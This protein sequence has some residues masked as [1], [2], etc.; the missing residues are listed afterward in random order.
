MFTSNIRS[1]SLVS[2]LL[3][4]AVVGCVRSSTPTVVPSAVKPPVVAAPPIPPPMP[5][6]ETPEP[7]PPEPVVAAEVP[8]EKPD[9]KP[10]ATERLLLLAPQGPLIV[11]FELWI[12]GQ[13]QAD[14]FDRLL[15]E[16]LKLADTDLDGTATWKEVTTSPKFRYGQFGNLPI[17]R[18]NAP[19]QIIQQYDLDGDGRVDLA[20]LPRFLTR[21][22]GGA[23]AFSVRSIEQF[24]GRNRR[25]SPTWRALDTDN[26]GQLTKAE[27]EA[28]A[29][30]LRLLD[31]D[32]DET[33]VVGELRRTTEVELMPGNR[34]RGIRGDFARVLGEH[35]NWD[36]IRAALEE[37]YALGGTL[38]SDDFGEQRELFIHLDEDKDGKIG[39]KEFP[40]LNTAR[41]N[42][43]LRL[44]FGQPTVS[45]AGSPRTSPMIDVAY[46]NL[47]PSREGSFPTVISWPNRVTFRSP[48]VSLKFVRNDTLAT[49]DF[50]AQAQQGLAM[51]DA[52]ANGY[53][54]SS[55]VSAAVQQQFGRFEALD[56]DADGKVY[57]LEIT[58]FLR[59]RQGA[60]RVQVHARVQDQEDSLF[61]ALD[62]N[63]DDRLDARELER[64]AARLQQL[65]A[66]SDGAITVDELPEEIVI[67]IA[68]GSI[69]N[70]EQLFAVGPVETR[71]PSENL[72]SWF[73]AMDTS[74][75]G[76][77]SAKEFLGSAEKF[78]T[79]DRNQNG[80]FEPDEIPQPTSPTKEVIP[81]PAESTERNEP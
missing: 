45:Q 26:D 17:D 16:V 41:S 32:D 48:G 81:L 66:N 11:E 52:D 58:D 25:G 20:E 14:E 47:L 40:R 10:L 29:A 76:V 31:S 37:Q 71:A 43:F 78:A 64:A 61:L 69:E 2:I 27:I 73:A 74:R 28:A 22:A 8:T 54:E 42:L 63:A 36:S 38:G 62:E 65:D 19:K 55:E 7:A 33:L 79:L 15:Q 57:L 1:L 75:D 53:L 6:V 51:Y 30:Q 12:D 39:R 67:V 60:Q 80:F 9:E 68:R 44:Q 34:T 46:G 50:A 4:C 77:I 13:P 23:R 18:E 21:N 5:V 72:P 35:A 24:H 56:A 3:L 59:Q 70:Q 49:V